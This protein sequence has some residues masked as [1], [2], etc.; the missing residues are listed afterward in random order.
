MG[1]TILVLSPA[2]LYPTS[3][4]NRRR[5]RTVCE[6][7]L[8]RGYDVDFA[9][10][11]HEDEIYRMFGHHAPN[12]MQQASR[13]FRGVFYIEPDDDIRIKT[14]S[15]AFLLDDWH[16]PQVDLFMSWYFETH[17]DTIAVVVNYVFLSAALLRAPKHV[18]KIIDAHDRFADRQIMY[19]SYRGEPNFFYLDRASEAEGLSRADFILAIQEAEKAYFSSIVGVPVHLF[20]HR[21]ERVQE[22][23]AHLG[24]VRSIG[25]IGH[26]N[27]A[28]VVSI[29]KFADAW[30]KHHARFGGP[31]LK[32]AGEVCSI[33]G[34]GGPPGVK[35][36]GY[37]ERLEDFY[38]AVDVVVTPLIIGTGLKIKTVE[39]LA[40]GKPVI[41]TRLAFEGLDP[42]YEAHCCEN[43]E[44]VV[45]AVAALASSSAQGEALCRASAEIFQRYAA[46]A[47]AA[48]NSFFDAFE[49]RRDAVEVP[50][51]DCVSP[52]RAQAENSPILAERLES[53]AVVWRERNTESLAVE[54]IR[55][56]RCGEAS[57]QKFNGRLL[58]TE[59]RIAGIGDDAQALAYAFAPERDR[60]FLAEGGRDASQADLPLECDWSTRLETFGPQGPTALES[61]ALSSVDG[62]QLSAR[63]RDRLCAVLLAARADWTATAKILSASKYSVSITTLAPPGLA[64]A[65]ARLWGAL[66]VRGGDREDARAAGA[67]YFGVEITRISLVEASGAPPPEIR[68]AV[69]A[70]ARLSLVPVE[71][72]FRLARPAPSAPAEL[73]LKFGRYI[74]AV[75]LPSV[76]PDS[77][78]GSL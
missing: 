31:I 4:G 35:L 65:R 25:F 9:L 62:A 33:F 51:A 58:A 38:A 7:L 23:A 8:E 12:D 13:L 50:V 78:Q 18:I 34:G 48:E 43:V 55:V 56:L 30:S 29:S 1:K 10:Y 53:G 52:K 75:K 71:L 24:A 20:L 11:G 22:P 3:A 6:T 54:G 19:A 72:A 59:R 69:R 41:G 17:P 15:R 26:G 60:W 21:I 28:N 66:S 77:R 37:C 49:K 74:G 36:L 5:I 47:K 73:R 2:P 16:S 46:T 32:I 70:G 68:A 67:D 76:E 42:T 27:D 39:A 40:H 61:T 45:G 57:A 63:D 44:A 64:Q 14:K